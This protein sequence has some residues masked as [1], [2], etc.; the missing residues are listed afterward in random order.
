MNPMFSQQIVGGNV[1]PVVIDWVIRVQKNGGT[2][3]SQNTISAVNHLYHNIATTAILGK[4]KALNCYVPD[5]LT[6]CLTPLLK[7]Y[8]NDP[9]TNSNFVSADLTINGLVG[10]GGSQF[11]G[12]K[13]LITGVLG[14][15]YSADSTAGMTLYAYTSGLNGSDGGT[16]DAGYT[17]DDGSDGTSLSFH[18]SN[19][20]TLA[21]WAY[22]DNDG[23]ALGGEC[24]FNWGSFP[25][26]GQGYLSGNRISTSDQ[27]LY[28]GNSSNPHAQVGNTVTVGTGARGAHSIYF[29]T[30][31]HWNF[32][33]PFGASTSRISFAA[34]HD[35]LTA[36]ESSQFY[37]F[38]QSF[39]QQI[40]GG[41][42]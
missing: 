36:S 17:N 29:H 1:S 16:Y 6:A 34:I 3:P 19:A 10:N 12:A 14:T 4:I 42:V 39:R 9:W 31:N 40:G 15:D 24:D 20:T 27:R 32:G 38:I 33:G 41:W 26:M 2:K 23:G 28:F 18:R 30:T 21:Y 8:G 5:N 25:S 7:T 13:Y 11:G 37:S 35:G 22:K